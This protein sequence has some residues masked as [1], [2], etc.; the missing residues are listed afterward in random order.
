M[1]NPNNPVKL[2]PREV[3]LEFELEFEFE[4]EREFE[5]EFEL[6]CGCEERFF[7]ALPESAGRERWGAVLP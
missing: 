2:K 6:E 7:G 1:R 4:L 5:F 3:E